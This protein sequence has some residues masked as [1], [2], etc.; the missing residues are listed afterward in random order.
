MYKKEVIFNLPAQYKCTHFSWLIVHQQ[1]TLHTVIKIAALITMDWYKHLN[2]P[3]YHMCDK[4]TP[5]TKHNTEKMLHKA[6]EHFKLNVKI[7]NQLIF[8]FFTPGT[9]TL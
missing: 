1:V 6:L 7:L 9:H 4:H 3:K 2:R 5:N 8:L